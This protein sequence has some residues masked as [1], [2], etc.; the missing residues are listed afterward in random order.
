[1]KD[2]TTPAE[3]KRLNIEEPAEIYRP[4]GCTACNHTGY[5]GRT[6]VFE[7]MV[8]DRKMREFLEKEEHTA[9]EL[10]TMARSRGMKFLLDSCQRQVINGVTS[11]E[12]YD[13][14]IDITEQA[15]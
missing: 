13:A 11:I 1:V 12:E 3:M 10:R 5:R 4:S 8:V 7:I 15:D 6:A 14:L 2:V 9:E